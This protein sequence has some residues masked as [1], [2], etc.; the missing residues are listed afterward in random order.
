[1]IRLRFETTIARPPADVWAYAADLGRHTEWMEVA[2]SEVIAGPTDAVGARA[3]QVLRIGPARIAYTM[4]ATEAV[5][6][7]L[8]WWRID[9]GALIGGGGGLQLR[10]ASPAG[11]HV[12][13]EVQIALRGWLRILEPIVAREARTSEARELDRLKLRL[14]AQ[15][16]SQP[17]GATMR[18]GAESAAPVAISGVES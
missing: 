17:G 15:A 18:T 7:R 1:M 9:D 10:P 3:R 11:T 13:Y 5:P 14:E 4:T 6:G 2:S 12:V 16:P 8:I